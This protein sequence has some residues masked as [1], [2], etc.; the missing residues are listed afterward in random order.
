VEPLQ[1]GELKIVPSQGASG[2]PI[3]RFW[4]GR[5]LDRHPARA[6]VPYL[7][8]VLEEALRQR[9]RVRLHFETLEFMN[10][11]T[12]TAVI[13]I[14]REAREKNVGLEIVFDRQTEWQRLS[15]DA[16]AVLLRGDDLLRLV[17]EPARSR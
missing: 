1:L 5:S 10:S 12:I 11:S 17:G 8:G 3:A 16:L 14:I 15:F 9:T 4:H 6:I 2:E 7:G 13:Q